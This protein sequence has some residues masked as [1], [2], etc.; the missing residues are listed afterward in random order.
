M[1]HCERIRADAPGLMTL[2]ATDPERASALAHAA[3]C[4]GCEKALR[5]ADRLQ[6]L[7]GEVTP[8][9]L[10]ASA[11]AR[12]T[13][14]I[15]QELRREQR[16]RSLWSAGAAAA[17]MA[18]LVGLAR[19]RN[20]S[21]GDWL[22]AGGVA[23]VALALAAL[24]VRRPLVALAG[25]AAAALAAAV[26]TGGP[27]ALEPG[28]GLHCLFTELGAAAA[29]VGAGWLALRGGATSPA[30]WAVAAAAAAG[31][32]AGGAALEVTCSAHGALSHDVVFH[33]G[34]VVLA[35]GLAS[36]LGRRHAAAVA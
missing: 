8:A 15:E 10:P 19:H 30:R 7:L 34:G 2:P 14:A 29:V 22:V 16:R 17:L 3:G 27:G 5:D 1:T 32:L 35:A 12:A 13:Q 36:L 33:L 21:T 28:T 11:L 4:P 20:G 26:A 9:P 23:L 6:A 25:G 18:V 31:A 24:S